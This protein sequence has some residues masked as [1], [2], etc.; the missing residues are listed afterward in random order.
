MAAAQT[1]LNCLIPRFI[2]GL[3][4]RFLQTGDVLS[5]NIIS[6]PQYT[7]DITVE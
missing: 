5:F 3:T 7:K 1:V 6:V 2:S 4:L